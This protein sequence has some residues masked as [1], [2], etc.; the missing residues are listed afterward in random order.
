MVLAYSQNSR[1]R[2]ELGLQYPSR[3]SPH[4]YKIFYLPSDFYGEGLMLILAAKTRKKYRTKLAI[5][6]VHSAIVICP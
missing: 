5:W 3:F 2:K 4:L 6:G 1:N